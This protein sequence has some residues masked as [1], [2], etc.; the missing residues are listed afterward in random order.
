VIER[1]TPVQNRARQNPPLLRVVGFGR[2]V[3]LLTGF[4]EDGTHQA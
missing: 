2:V 1:A 3:G 4:D